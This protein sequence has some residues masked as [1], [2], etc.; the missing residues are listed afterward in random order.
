M[1]H[2][3]SPSRCSILEQLHGAVGNNSHRAWSGVAWRGVRTEA[4][5]TY[6]YLHFETAEHL[7]QFRGATGA[8]RGE[9]TI[10]IGPCYMRA[11]PYGAQQ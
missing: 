5:L 1:R 11:T 6:E 8:L 3:L 7:G 9:Y 2:I 10:L 4:S